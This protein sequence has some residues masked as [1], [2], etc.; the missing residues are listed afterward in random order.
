VFQEID[1]A[2]GCRQIGYPLVMKVIGPLHKTDLNGVR[3]NIT[4]DQ[5][6]AEAWNDLMAI[7]D[8]RG[9]LLQ[10]MVT[11]PEVILGVGGE[12]DF[13]HLVMFGLGGIYA[14]ALKDITFG[15]APLTLK[16]AR[17]MIDGIRGHAIVEGTRGQ[18]GMDLDLLADMITR[19][20][21][22]VADFPQIEEIDLNP[23]KGVGKNLYAV[24]ARIIVA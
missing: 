9:A 12:G 23:V 7:R 8:S 13:G 2:A 5:E 10:P 11:G 24:D 18:A 3:L 15:L 22:L 21:K 19:L 17:R 14:E 16:E 1:L 6:A 4:D 20:G